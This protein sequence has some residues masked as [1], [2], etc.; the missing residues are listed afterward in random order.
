[1]KNRGI[2]ILNYSMVFIY[3]VIFAL[4][5]A[6]VHL[7]LIVSGAKVPDGLSHISLGLAETGFSVTVIAVSILT[8]ITNMSDRR[9]FGIKAGE[10]LRFRR[11]KFAPGFYDNLVIIVL[12]GALQYVA[13][14]FNAPFASAVLF[15]GIIALMV[16]Q[17]RWGIGIAFFY[18]GKEKEIKNFFMEELSTNLDII[19]TGKSKSKKVE[20]ALLAVGAR[21][22]QLFTHTKRAASVRETSEVAQNLSML[23]HVLKILLNPAYQKVWHNYETR[24]DHLLSSLLQDDE[25]REY[26]LSA[27]SGMMDII[28][29]TIKNTEPQKEIA[30]NCDFDNSRNESYKLVCY[31][32]VK[33]LKSMFEEQL[34]Y[35]LAVVKIFGIKGDARKVSRYAHY[36]DI[37]ARRAADSEHIEELQE[38]IF[39]SITALVPSCFVDGKTQEGGL[40]TCVLIESLLKNDISLKLL[41]HALIEK[42]FDDND[43]VQTQ[44][45]AYILILMEKE[46]F[47][48]DRMPL[49]PELN[50]A[51]KKMIT[52]LAKLLE[53]NIDW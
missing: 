17:I 6:L 20:R 35:K 14:G 13:L 29:E 10:Y 46:A 32:P 5:A 18:Y 15:I 44:K 36:T 9:Y 52:E 25:H 11:R 51:D 12:V 43:D 31:A 28:I 24:L 19:T 53:K 4:I 21:I 16:V 27:L 48:I 50:D 37:F 34:F 39:D 38:M 45:S 8:V 49:A 41:G 33:T 23:A 2:R 3:T 1:M 30:Q 47:Q 22:D 42:Y 26:A 7:L 40:Y